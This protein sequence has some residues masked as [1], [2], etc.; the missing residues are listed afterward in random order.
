MTFRELPVALKTS[1]RLAQK[2][3]S[4]SFQK[5]VE[6]L[7][8]DGDPSLGAQLLVSFLEKTRV[9]FW[10]ESDAVVTGTRTPAEMI[11]EISMHRKVDDAMATGRSS[12]TE[13]SK[14]NFI[15]R[16]NARFVSGSKQVRQSK[17]ELSTAELRKK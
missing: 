3:T 4:G 2:P 11:A 15:Q 12:R 5:P 7:R 8:V 10:M 16:R 17:P 9:T 1:S 6:K 14:T 13:T